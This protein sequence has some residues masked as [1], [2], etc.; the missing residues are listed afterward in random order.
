[1]SNT[2]FTREEKNKMTFRMGENETE[3]DLVLI[4]KTPMFHTHCQD[5]TLGVSSCI[6]G[7]RHR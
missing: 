3:I 1:M 7:N 5:N 4:K 6:S 2:W